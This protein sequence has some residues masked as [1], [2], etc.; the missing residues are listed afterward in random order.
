MPTQ[1][2]LVVHKH[3]IITMLHFPHTTKFYWNDLIHN[4][5]PKASLG[6]T[7]VGTICQ[8]VYICVW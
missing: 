5:P 2:I 6:S 4:T 8:I 7:L 3:I 1:N